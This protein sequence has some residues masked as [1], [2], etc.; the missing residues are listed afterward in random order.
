MRKIINYLNLNHIGLL[1]LVFSFYCILAGYNWGVI[2]GNLIFI[3]LMAIIALYRKHNTSFRM[4]ELAWVSI[5]VVLHELI[6]MF[7]ISGPG[8]MFNNTVSMALVCVSIFPIS[9]ALQYKKIVGSLNWISL[10]SIGGVIYHFFIIRNGGFVTPISLP[11]LPELDTSSRLFE[12]GFRPTSFYAEPAA[13]VTFMMV[14]L[15]ISLFERKFI[16]SGIIVFSMF[17]STSTTGITMSILML[18]T[19]VLT[20]KVSIRYKVISTLLGMAFIYILFNGDIFSAGLD[21]INETDIETTSRVANGPAM[22]FNMPYKDLILGMPAANPYDYYISGGFS[23]S[24]II[25][26]EGSIFCSTFWLVLAKFGVFGLLLYLS[27]YIKALTQSRE[28][29]PFIIMLFVSMFFQGIAIGSS[30]FA[31]QIIFIYVFVN[32]IQQTRLNR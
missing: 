10:L 6:L 28:I 7:A 15:F 12:E 1:E 22:V 20:Q 14:P 29:L 27:V 16:W 9:K 26:K 31:F 11:F 13:F 5:F 30:G 4:K 21:K 18:A 24:T 2:K 23:S 8:Y 17:L 19:Y 3:I 32:Y 25:V